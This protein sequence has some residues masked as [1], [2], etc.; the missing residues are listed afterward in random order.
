[1]ANIRSSPGPV[2]EEYALPLDLPWAFRFA[3]G[4]TLVDD[5]RTVLSCSDSSGAWLR[6][7][8]A[9]KGADITA[10]TTTLA[11]G[12]GAW[13]AIP[14]ATLVANLPLT[15]STTNARAGATLEVVRLDVGAFTVPLTNG[16]TGGG[17][18][19]TLPISVRSFAR[20]Y[21]NGIDWE[22]RRSGLLL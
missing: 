1:V 21:F 18:L 12:D 4:S 15:L 5:G 2:G 8:D 11:V 13:R 9:D 16:G 19:T 10:A 3:V 22:P 17:L 14:A 7:Y 6:V 20:F